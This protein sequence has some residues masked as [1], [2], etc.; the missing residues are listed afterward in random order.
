MTLHIACS[1]TGIDINLRNAAQAVKPSPPVAHITFWG[2]SRFPIQSFIMFR[3]ELLGRSLS[4]PLLHEYQPMLSQ[5]PTYHHNTPFCA[6]F[7]NLVSNPSKL[8]C[9]MPIPLPMHTCCHGI[10]IPQ[11]SAP[12]SPACSLCSLHSM[13]TR[14][15][16]CFSHSLW[17]TGS[18]HAHDVFHH[19]VYTQVLRI[20]W[21]PSHKCPEQFA[22]HQ[23]DDTE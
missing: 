13:I 10:H 19:E 5:S 20:F 16:I 22:Y 3:S 8:S 7:P 23:E 12:P 17:L 11:D 2:T 18:S 4:I 15:K 21:H 1:L 9:W 14:F 6:P